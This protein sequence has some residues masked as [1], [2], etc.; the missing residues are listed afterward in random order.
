MRNDFDSE[1]I[2][3]K[4][5]FKGRL[6]IASTYSE[7][8]GRDVEKWGR[9][10]DE[11]IERLKKQLCANAR[12]REAVERKRAARAMKVVH[13]D[14]KRSDCDPPPWPPDDDDGIE[15]ERETRG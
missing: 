9:S 1:K 13:A 2:K 7:Y 5:Y 10:A 14:W 15:L 11:A 3:A 4:P 6:W 8:W 12:S